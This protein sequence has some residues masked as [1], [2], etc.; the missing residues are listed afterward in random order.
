MGLCPLPHL[1]NDGIFITVDFS[2]RTFSLRFSV[3][4]LLLLN[5]YPVMNEKV[6][7]QNLSDPRGQIH[8]C[9][10]FRVFMAGLLCTVRTGVM[11]IPQFFHDPRIRELLSSSSLPVCSQRDLLRIKL[12][13]KQGFE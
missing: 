3:Y 10:T 6:L 8:I 5:S 12:S 4:L 9:I 1:S 7:E 13:L 2:P 11:H